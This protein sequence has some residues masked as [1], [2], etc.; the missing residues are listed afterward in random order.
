MTNIAC[1]LDVYRRAV[2]FAGG[3]P[4]VRISALQRELRIGYNQAVRLID[5]MQAAGWVFLRRREN[6]G[7]ANFGGDILVLPLRDESVPEG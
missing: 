2:A 6:G 7:P 1:E 5:C 4:H 3:N